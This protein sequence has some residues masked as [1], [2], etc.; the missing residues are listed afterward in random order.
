MSETTFHW[1]YFV[2]V[3]I[4]SV[5]RVVYT[6]HLR[7]MKVEEDR[8]SGTDSWLMSLPAL[9]MFVFPVVHVSSSWLDFADYDTPVWAGWIGVGLLAA[10]MFLLWRTHVDLGLNWT[11]SL[12]LRHGHTLVTS[13]VYARIR[14][15]MYTAHALWALALP[16]LMHNWIAGWGMLATIVPPLV[17]RIPRE[18]EQLLDHYGAEYRQYMTRTGRLVPRLPTGQ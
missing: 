12:Q 8:K 10:A 4:A 15:P 1:F 16:L 2:G 9:G 13:G 17:W 5:I 3:G 18:E 11:P 7:K 6:R 14:H